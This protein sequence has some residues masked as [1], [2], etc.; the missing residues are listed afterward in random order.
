MLNA[1]FRHILSYRP[2]QSCHLMLHLTVCIACLLASM[3]TLTHNVSGENCTENIPQI[4]GSLV[5]C[6]TDG[7]KFLFY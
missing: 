5:N 4:F 2:N 1:K 6:K 3:L 7:M